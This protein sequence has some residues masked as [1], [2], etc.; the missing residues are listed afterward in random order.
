MGRV[1]ENHAIVSP[2][3]DGKGKGSNHLAIN[4]DGDVGQTVTLNS[5]EYVTYTDTVTNSIVTFP[6]GTFDVTMTTSFQCF[7]STNVVVETQDI[8]A[9]E[10]DRE[11]IFR[12]WFGTETLP[13]GIAKA[14]IN[15]FYP[16]QEGPLGGST[17]Y[18]LAGGSETVF[19][20][21]ATC[22][23]YFQNQDYGAS[24]LVLEQ[25]SSGI[26]IGY[27]APGIVGYENSNGANI[28]LGLKPDIR[29]YTI[30]E[31][32]TGNL[33]NFGPNIAYDSSFDTTW[34]VSGDGVSNG[35]SYIIIRSTDGS[36]TWVGTAGDQGVNASTSYRIVFRVPNLSYVGQTFTLYF[37][38]TDSFLVTITGL[39]T[40]YTFA[41]DATPND[42]IYFTRSGIT[43]CKLIDYS[44]E[45]LTTK[46]ERTEHRTYKH[47]GDKIGLEL[48]D[49]NL[50][51]LRGDELGAFNSSSPSSFEATVTTIG[52]DA[53]KP[54]LQFKTTNMPILSKVRIRFTLKV[55]SGIAHLQTLRAGSDG[56][57][58]VVNKELT[59][60]YYEYDT[61]SGTLQDGYLVF[62]GTNLYDIEVTSL[63][64][65]ELYDENVYKIDN[66]LQ[67]YVPEPPDVDTYLKIDDT[68]IIGYPDIRDKTSCQFKFY[69]GVTT[70]DED[71]SDFIEMTSCLA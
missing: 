5:D 48:L 45:E 68:P 2:S 66:V 10:I 63:S 37:S 60:G 55:N 65:R 1:F 64:G 11:L 14:N 40:E 41:R 29:R 50:T 54:Q 58:L 19:G 32:V 21:T 42:R 18:N 3:Y 17:V 52:T 61:T 9:M 22:R 57:E 4:E 36:Y 51:I 28:E 70:L 23:T 6:D 16:A 15:S 20:Y 47:Y 49:A 7:F 26:I 8:A 27:L 35:D 67:A 34:T 53:S 24:N 56:T 59:S 43:E 39:T 33:Q 62:K 31:V 13:S 69:T 38:S 44:I 30:K 71:E 12:V 25:D 46:S